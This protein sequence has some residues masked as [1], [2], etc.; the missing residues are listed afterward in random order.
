LLIFSLKSTSLRQDNGIP[1]QHR[2]LKAQTQECTVT[3]IAD[4][5]LPG[6]GEVVSLEETF[7]CEISPEDN[8]G[9]SGH[10]REIEGTSA[11]IEKL[12][13]LLYTGELESG[14][15]TLRIPGSEISEGGV[16]LPAGEEITLGHN[17]RRK[18]LANTGDRYFLAVRVAAS[19]KVVAATA[20][21]ISD[22]IFGTNGDTVNMVSQFDACSYGKFKII[23]G[24]PPGTDI[25]SSL[26]APGVIDVKIPINLQDT[27]STRDAVANAITTAVQEK[28][29]FN[30]PGPFDAVMYI[31]EGCYVGDC[32]SWGAYA[33]INSWRSV[34]R[35][36]YYSHAA[37]Q[38]HEI[39][40]NLNLA[41]SRGLDGAEYTDHTCSVSC[42]YD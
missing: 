24:P 22:D 34:Y 6:L 36:D 41:H 40:H 20:A 5:R 23:P 2:A 27:T 37:V 31:V 7:V 1:D 12:R 39:G 35:N 30:L 26:A 11:Q 28:L 4:T 19:D 18:L 16:I 17:G 9:E 8:D 25:S 10:I 3:A 32:E 42:Y 13:E 33:S 29:G 14:F 38:V 21:S 15:S